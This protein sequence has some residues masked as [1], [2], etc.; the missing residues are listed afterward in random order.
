MPASSNSPESNTS[1]G[2]VNA[3]TVAIQGESFL[4][5]LVLTNFDYFGCIFL[6]F[7]GIVPA[8]STSP[9]SNRFTGDGNVPA[10]FSGMFSASQFLLTLL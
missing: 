10:I 5:Q 9:K 8:S 1:M 2:H 3:F 7:L 4:N 6:P